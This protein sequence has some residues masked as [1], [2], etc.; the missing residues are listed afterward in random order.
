ME[1]FAIIPNGRFIV[2]G[3]LGVK[4]MN[5]TSHVSA[6]AAQIQPHPVKENIELL[7]I[8]EVCELT[9]LSKATIWNKLNHNSKYYDS[10]FPKQ[11]NLSK[12]A[13]A[14][15]KQDVLHWIEG[16]RHEKNNNQA[17]Q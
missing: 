11:V 10:S 7:R 17:V 3:P 4:V 2:I 5:E 16:L 6:S 12:K 14:W 13:V 1:I 15:Y 9:K 8:K